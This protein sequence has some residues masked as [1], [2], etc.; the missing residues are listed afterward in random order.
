M[1]Y[2][3]L[4]KTTVVIFSEVEITSVQ[5]NDIGSNALDLDNYV[6]CNLRGRSCA[7]MV[8]QELVDDPSSDKDFCESP[9]SLCW[10][11]SGEHPG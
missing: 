9:W 7:H 4:Y 2:P 11:P 8:K 5:D 6:Q 1:G 10:G 3:R